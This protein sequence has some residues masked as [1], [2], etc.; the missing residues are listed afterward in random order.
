MLILLENGSVSCVPLMVK[1]KAP[2]ISIKGAFLIFYKNYCI[3][4]IENKKRNKK[5]VD[6]IMTKY[7]PLL[8]IDFYKATHDSQYPAD[9]KLIYS[10]YTPRMSR[11]KDTDRVTYFGGQG[12][13]KEFLIEAFNNNFFNRPEEE[14]VRE[15]NRVLTCTLGAGAYNPEKVVALHRLGYLPIAVF[16]VPEGT[17]TKIGVPQSV[18]V[19]THPDFAWLTNTLETAYSSYMW[20][21][22]VSAE[23][24]VRYRNIVEKYR[25]LS[26][27]DDVRTA[28]LLGDFSMRGQH[29]PESAMHSSAG[30]LTS[31]LNTATVPAIMWL[32]DYYNCNIENEEV[33]F[34]AISTEHSVMCSNYAVDGDEIT[35]IKRLLTEIY[36][37]HNF[38]MVSD[39]YD[40]W[41]LV[42]NLLPQCKNEI[43]AHKGLFSIRGDSGDP[44]EIMAGKKFHEID[45]SD[46][47]CLL[48]NDKCG[49]FGIFEDIIGEDYDKKVYFYHKESNTYYEAEVSAEM[50]RE[51][52]GWTDNNYYFIEDYNYTFNQIEPSAKTHGLIWALDRI[53]GS[54]LNS[55]GYK[56]LNHGLRG[57]YGDSIT[58]QRCEE[59]YARLTAQG[60]AI[61]NIT[62][63][64]GSFSFMCLETYDEDGNVHYNPYT[65]DTFGIAIKATYGEDK[66]GN[67]IMIYKQPKECSWKK[68]QKGC[69]IVAPDGE[70]YTDGHT[71]EEF[72]NSVD[73]NKNLLELVFY[74]GEMFKEQSIQE[75][76]E[77]LWGKF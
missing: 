76:R 27:D 57:I 10:P 2:L 38:S 77:R 36:P 19:N 39:S 17:R 41:N 40:F 53:V 16:A 30:W 12:F 6:I 25:Q 29:S 15:Y 34:G 20:H 52:G 47:E 66:D 42:N 69:V 44:V 48:T 37:N 62:L 54:T 13:I 46:L 68:S 64:V 73:D 59:T 33:G 18:F 7:N 75:I 1:L 24:G 3:I 51:R 45:D 35:H 26:C 74:N 72:C 65:R 14:V 31:F 4:F 21:I 23:V 28:R 71:Y 43:I 8:M 11:L 67:P 22:Q 61:N 49:Y 5:G 9:M 32:E 56:V 70:S 63:G 50:S 60:Y 58:P 55:K